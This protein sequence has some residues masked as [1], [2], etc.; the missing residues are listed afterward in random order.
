MY[1]PKNPEGSAPS[2]DPISD[3][4]ANASVISDGA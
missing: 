3:E 4:S 1:L 2:F